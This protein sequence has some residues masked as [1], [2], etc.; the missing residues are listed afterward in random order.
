VREAFARA[1]AWR[2]T[3]STLVRALLYLALTALAL[4]ILWPVIIVITTS[5]KPASEINL[6]NFTLFP[7]K[8]EFLNYPT[9]MT[10]GDWPRYFFNSAFVTFW[11]VVGS[12]LFNSL[13]GYSFARLKFK[14][15][16]ILFAFFL[17]GIMIP[18]QSLLI[19]QFIIMHHIPLAGGNNII[20]N[21]GD[22]WI[23]SFWALIVPQLSGSFG[24]FLCRQ[25]YLGF[26]WS[27]DDAGSAASGRTATARKHQDADSGHPGRRQAGTRSRR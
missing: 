12:L 25:F 14:G 11:S 2:R 21:G 5:L 22:G 20:G 6:V 7:K 17:I 13:A 4:I 23:N 24:I 26:P 15:H 1:D 9:A 8:W 19:P 3:R 27:L 16:Q 18:P 10:Q